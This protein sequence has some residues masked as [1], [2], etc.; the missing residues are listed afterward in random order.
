[1]EG[2]R[3]W[4]SSNVKTKIHILTFSQPICSQVPLLNFKAEDGNKKEM[5]I[6]LCDQEPKIP[7]TYK[8]T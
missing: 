5:T 2:E 1:M 7:K 4:E 8:E 6:Q 3:V